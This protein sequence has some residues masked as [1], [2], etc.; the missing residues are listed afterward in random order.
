M[1]KPPPPS[2][3]VYVCFSSISNYGPVNKGQQ[4]A[5]CTQSLCVKYIARTQNAIVTYAHH[6][7]ETHAVLCVGS[8]GK[9]PGNGQFFTVFSKIRVTFLLFL[10]QYFLK[11]CP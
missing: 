6:T 1:I 11:I 8:G 2:F 10:R 4:P 9:N 5:V 7:L 3:S